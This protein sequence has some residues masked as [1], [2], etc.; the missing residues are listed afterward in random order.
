[1]TIMIPSSAR[2]MSLGRSRQARKDEKIRSNNKEQ[3]VF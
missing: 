3:T 2:R 1:M